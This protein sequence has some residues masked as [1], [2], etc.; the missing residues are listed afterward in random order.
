MT[1]VAV[2]ERTILTDL[3]FPVS[4]VQVT[5]HYLASLM[6]PWDLESMF[7]PSFAPISASGSTPTQWMIVMHGIYGRGGNW[8][9]FARKLCEQKPEWGCLLVDLRMHGRSMLA[10]PPHDLDAC[11]R[12]LLSLIDQQAQSGHTVAAVLG[13]SFGGKV[14]LE[15]RRLRP[16]LP[17]LWVID[18]SPSAFP[19][20]MSDSGKS[21]VAVLRM[22]E[23]LPSHFE[24]RNSFLSVVQTSGFDKNLALWLAMNLEKEGD[25][26]QLSLQA[27][28][29]NELLTDY[30]S[31][32]LWSVMEAH[33]EAIHLVCATLGS[34]LT[35]DDHS[36]LREL[37]KESPVQQHSLD[38]GHWLHV[39]ALEP[40]VTLVTSHLS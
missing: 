32:D 26:Y 30:F 7:L 22:L 27:P 39:D 16:A 34:A 31:R 4:F 36:R 21:V 28:A 5:C 18:S 40:L 25:R 15:M 14:A 9:S 19:K 24:S 1:Q 17:T 11:A 2:G 13:H 29:M 10:P 37:S 23:T 8:R 38:G 12:D 20:A 6:L 3:S 33:G 35:D